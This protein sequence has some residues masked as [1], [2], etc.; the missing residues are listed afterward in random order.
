MRIITILTQSGIH[1]QF[2]DVQQ[3]GKCAYRLCVFMIPFEGSWYLRITVN[4][5]KYKLLN[6]ILAQNIF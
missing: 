1:I 2:L 3:T 5:K 6:K 4:H